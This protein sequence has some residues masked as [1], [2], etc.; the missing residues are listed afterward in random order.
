MCV[1]FLKKETQQILISPFPS[2]WKYLGR[3]IW[4]GFGENIRILEWIFNRCAGTAPAVETPIGFLPPVVCMYY[5][6][7]IYGCLTHWID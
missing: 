6:S 1:W 3:F 2:S 7:H 5:C 4:P